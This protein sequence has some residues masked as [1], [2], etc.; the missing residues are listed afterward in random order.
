MKVWL[1]EQTVYEGS[2]LLY[3]ELLKVFDSNQKALDF[4][5]CFAIDPYRHFSV[6]EMEVE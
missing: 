1:V 5:N 3:V 4:I 2:E 6:R